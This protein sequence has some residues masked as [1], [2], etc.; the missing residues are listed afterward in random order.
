MF[1]AG[2]DS[3]V[4]SQGPKRRLTS[5]CLRSLGHPALPLCLVHLKAMTTKQTNMYTAHP[6]RLHCIRGS[7][8]VN[9]FLADA[10]AGRS[11]LTK[12]TDVQCFRVLEHLL[13]H[14]PYIHLSSL[15]SF[16][17]IAEFGNGFSGFVASTLPGLSVRIMALS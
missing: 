14:I 10:D 2:R 16:W 4:C 1:G 3:T 13:T 15:L 11:T 6:K 9:M 12:T 7:L 5:C 8:F 17:M